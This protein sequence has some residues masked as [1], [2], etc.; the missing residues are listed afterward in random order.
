M[1]HPS[2]SNINPLLSRQGPLQTLFC[3]H[4]EKK[5]NDLLALSVCVCI[6]K[7]LYTS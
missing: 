7:T 5:A 6:I 4:Y 2:L 3:L 1:P